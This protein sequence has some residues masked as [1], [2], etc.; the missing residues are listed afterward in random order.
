MSIT[1]DNQISSSWEEVD[2]LIRLLRLW[3]IEYLVGLNNCT[4][5]AVVKED[6]ESAV[7]LIQKLAQCDEYPRVRDAS[8]SLFLLHPELADA[9]IEAL[10]RSEPALAEQIAVLTLA[11]LYLQ[12]LWS[13]RLALALGHPPSFPEQLF[14]FLWQ[15]RHLPPP[16]AHNGKWGLLAL[17]EVVQKRTGLPFTF[18]GDWQN[19]I[20]H[21]LLQEET[22]KQKHNKLEI[23]TELIDVID[24]R[25]NELGVEEAN[26][27]MRPSVDKKAI[28]AFLAQLGRNFRKP[29]RLYLVGGAALVHLGIRP[30][31]TQDIDVQVSGANEGELIVTI[32]QL[33]Q[34]MQI[35]VEFASPSD[36]IPLP[37]HWETHAQYVGHYGG[38]DVFY[39]D[40]YSIALSK[41]E[42][43][44]NRDIADV[45][46]LVQKGII[47]LNELDA[48]YQDV[49]AQLGHGRYPRITPQRFTERYA[50]IRQLL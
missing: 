23:P 43:G 7:T 35:N 33:M 20:D 46:I 14:A 36:F 5:V 12:R 34:Q 19:Q 26:M 25:Q 9:V 8:I 11:T 38:V 17:Q 24:E 40:F 29:G 21:L 27:S 22:K 47:D 3:G 4:T 37:A 50:A 16:V 15:S 45:R 28:D 18:L 49:L 39:F 32:Q 2:N 41:I 31:F 48:A 6:Q 1:S 13:I 44:N 30:G 10:H 42:R